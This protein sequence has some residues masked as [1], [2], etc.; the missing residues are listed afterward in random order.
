M[1]SRCISCRAS[2]GTNEVLEA[3]PVG[4]TLAFDTEKGRLWV[5]CRACRSW[6]L[7]P[8]L[9]R[10]EPLE[11]L[12][13]RFETA[14]IEASS[15]HMALGRV[16]DGTAL[17]RV[18]RAEGPELAFWRYANRIRRR[19]KRNT[20]IAGAGVG[21]AYVAASVVSLGLGTIAVGTGAWLALRKV[22]DVRRMGRV[23]GTVLRR[24][25]ARKLRMVPSEHEF[26]WSL[27]LPRL[28][29]PVIDG[30]A[31]L[32]ALRILLPPMNTV[33]GKADQVSA[34]TS[35][36]VRAGSPDRLMR[37]ATAELRHSWNIDPTHPGRE[38]PHRISTGLPEIRLALEMAT[39]EESE[40]RALDGEMGLLETEWREAEELAGISD[41]LLMPSEV[42][43]WIRSRRSNVGVG[44][45]AR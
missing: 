41:D 45:P 33:V 44:P 39:N 42:L 8:L 31:A 26:G 32:R 11:E 38:I 34:A 13:R 25:D 6:N 30:T 37:I 16:A 23:D 21:G 15:D 3:F 9:E 24:G 35:K 28:R 22:N 5:I 20:I 29:D 27:E 40:R 19:W 43:D 17:L 18:G 14:T 2:L 10:W 7:A 12:E 36:L 1:Y 4:R